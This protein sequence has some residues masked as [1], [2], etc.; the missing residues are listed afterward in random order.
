MHRA[1]AQRLC[2]V[3]YRQAVYQRGQ[4]R[5]GPADP[6]HPGAERSAVRGA[7][8]RGR[9]CGGDAGAPAA[10]V[11]RPLG[12]KVRRSAD[13][14]RGHPDGGF[15][16]ERKHQRNAD[17]RGGARA[18]LHDRGGLRQRHPL[19][20]HG[21]RAEG[22][23]HERHDQRNGGAEQGCRGHLRRSL[24]CAPGGP[25]DPKRRVVPRDPRA[26]RLRPDERRPAADAR[27][28]R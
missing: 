6:L 8:R 19:P 20:A 22:R 26:G 12:R 25:G 1:R 24:P 2:L 15:L 17:A 10:R 28:K 14:R 16:P 5:A 23:R 9:A 11:Y 27:W 21:L 18:R 7:K 3:P 13:G 4:Q